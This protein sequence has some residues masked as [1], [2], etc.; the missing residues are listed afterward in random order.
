[1]CMNRRWIKWI[2]FFAGILMVLPIIFTVSVFLLPPQYDD[3][4]LGEFMEKQE[5]LEKTEGK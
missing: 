3:T 2:V 1:M 4:Y 5:R